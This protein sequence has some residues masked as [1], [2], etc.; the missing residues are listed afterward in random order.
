V[1][2]EV[3]QGLSYGQEI[4]ASWCGEGYYLF[5]CLLCGLWFSILDEGYEEKGGPDTVHNNQFTVAS[6]LRSDLEEQQQRSVVMQCCIVGTGCDCRRMSQGC[7]EE[8][9][10]ENET[11][12]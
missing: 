8:L 11:R 4:T 1:T 12:R 3:M 10:N 5:D 2:M 6:T 7:Q 9:G